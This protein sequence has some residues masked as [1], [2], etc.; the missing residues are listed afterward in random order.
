MGLRVG[1]SGRGV[2]GGS[3]AIWARCGSAYSYN[4]TDPGITSTGSLRVCLPRK[5]LARVRDL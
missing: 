4:L 5:Q 3:E 2:R 1:L